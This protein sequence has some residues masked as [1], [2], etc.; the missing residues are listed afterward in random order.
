MKYNSKYYFKDCYLSK[1]GV[2]SDTKI[3]NEIS[4]YNSCLLG[5]INV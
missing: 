5:F 1:F 2:F 4:K 3:D